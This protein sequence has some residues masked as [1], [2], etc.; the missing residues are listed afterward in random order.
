MSTHSVPSQAEGIRTY[1]ATGATLT[2]LEALRMFNC[3][4]LGARIWELNKAGCGILKRMV[5]VNYA[6]NGRPVRVAQY[7]DPAAVAARVAAA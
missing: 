6:E 5:T 2:P 3:F 1:L 7:F 4:R